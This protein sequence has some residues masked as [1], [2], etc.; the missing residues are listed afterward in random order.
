MILND[1]M[2]KD[3][4]VVDFLRR[5]QKSD[6]NLDLFLTAKKA[7]N[8]D[9]STLMWDAIQDWIRVDK[10]INPSHWKVEK[11]IHNIG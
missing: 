10:E 4:E 1:E 2:P 11:K 5:L 3:E 7:S 9:W 6:A 8:L